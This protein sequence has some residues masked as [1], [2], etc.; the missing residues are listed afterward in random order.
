LREHREF[1]LS[2]GD[3]QTLAHKISSGCTGASR[4][5]IK[6]N[7]A[8]VKAGLP[9]QR[10][11]EIATT[12][13]RGSDDASNAFLTVFT[14]A[15]LES[16]LDLDASQALAIALELSESGS[17]D[18]KILEKNFNDLVEFCVAK[19]SLDLPLIQCARLGARVM[20]HG[21]ALRFPVA[22]DFIE[23]YRF[24]TED[25]K[26]NLTSGEALKVAEDV[27]KHGPEATKNFI[28][29]FE[30]A[31][32]KKGLDRSVKEAVEFGNTMAS[33]SLKKSN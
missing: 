8:L 11:I 13:A 12:F 28:A 10:S 6:V 31:V 18:V 20:N 21:A 2:D 19:K 16:L 33:R 27:T 5:F 23:L 32:S 24:L 25:K 7:N 29:A 1:S 26:I 14:G 15:Y 22:R 17:G 9:T 3:A 4:R 30:Y